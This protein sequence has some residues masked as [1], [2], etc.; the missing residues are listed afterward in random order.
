MGGNVARARM[1]QGFAERLVDGDDAA[2]GGIWGA[3]HNF[4]QAAPQ[5][6]P[7][8]QPSEENVRMLMDMGF[9]RE[10]VVAALQRANNDINVATTILLQEA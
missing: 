3:M 1:G 10:R 5:N 6:N 4:N 7:L 9:P 2:G 8:P